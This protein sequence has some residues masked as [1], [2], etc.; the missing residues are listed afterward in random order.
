MKARITQGF[1]NRMTPKEKPFDVL[2]TYLKGFIL[3]VEPSGT[4]SYFIRYRKPD[5]GKMTRYRI[6]GADKLTAAQARDEAKERLAG[7]ELGKDP[8]ADKRAARA[9]TLGS[10]IDEKY[11][12]WVI[13]NRKSGK[14][15]V[16]RLRACF[17]DLWDKRL[18]EVTAWAIEKWRS[19]QIK[20]RN[21]KAAGNRDIAC[22]KAALNKAIEWGDLQ[23]NPIQT[24][25]LAKVDRKGNIRT[26]RE[27]EE[28]R[29]W[30]ALTAR[31]ERIRHQRDSHNLW[32][33]S[34]GLP[35]LSDLKAVP[36]VDYLRPM[37]TLILHTGLR[38]GE[39]FSLTW[40]NV[41]LRNNEIVVRGETAKSGR[42]RTVPLNATARNVLQA[43]R[44]QSTGDSFVFPSPRGGGR[45]DNIKRS[46]AGV[47]READIEGPTLHTLR[48]TFASRTLARGADI[49]TVKE[50]LGHEDIKTTAIYLHSSKDQQ[51][52][53]V[54]NLVVQAGAN[55]IPFEE[56]AQEAAQVGPGD[57]NGG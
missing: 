42:T 38:R 18:S 49:Q 41:D 56:K 33:R 23:K 24:V 50:L 40:S 43:W 45:L 55:I 6:G 8:A 54:E 1:V 2:D 47:L 7:A 29:L 51:R 34:R 10:F 12:P 44:N 20:R 15:T 46:W 57:E 3:R 14:G 5:D 27:D 35:E 28:A 13:A 39:A 19:A 22:L 53:A 26:L 32:L 25:K 9:H 36:Y 11:A 30:L 21:S 52:A 31:E 16:A 4:M 17:G 37:L 48:H